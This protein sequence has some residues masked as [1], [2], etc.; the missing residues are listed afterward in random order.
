MSKSLEEPFGGTEMWS[1]AEKS[2][3]AHSAQTITGRL[4][5]ERSRVLSLRPGSDTER[6]PLGS[7][8][9]KTPQ[10]PGRALSYTHTSLQK[11]T[12]LVVAS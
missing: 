9:G 2:C 7:G 6:P 1:E 4:G 12:L 5:A 3:R 8:R 10:V 11:V